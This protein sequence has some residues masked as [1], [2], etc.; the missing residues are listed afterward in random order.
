VAVPEEEMGETVIVI[1]GIGGG[2]VVG[3]GISLVVRGSVGGGTGGVV[4]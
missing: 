1:E 3:G 2:A 4:I